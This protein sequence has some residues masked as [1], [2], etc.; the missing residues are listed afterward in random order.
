VLAI[1]VV[2]HNPL[3]R[4]R[5]AAKLLLARLVGDDGPFQTIM[6]LPTELVVRVTAERRG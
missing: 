1:T 5:R 4:G 2:R 6:M 3:E